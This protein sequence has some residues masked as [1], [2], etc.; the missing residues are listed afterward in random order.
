MS[1]SNHS[2]RRRAG[3]VT[4]YLRGARYWIYYRNGGQVRKPVGGNRSIAIALAAKVNAQLA[5]GAPTV[6]AFQPIDVTG[7]IAEWLD[8]HEHVRRS[9][10]ATVRRC[11]TA[12]AHLANYIATACGTHRAHRFDASTAEGFVR[13]LRTVEIS[14]DGHR[15]AKKRRMRDKGVVF[16][17]GT[18]RVRFNFAREQRHVPGYSPNPFAGLAIE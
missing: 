8:H 18:C 10:L 2:W 15:K 12:V 13:Y 14:P 6:L 3:R 7:L 9:S 4:V 17:L 1:R 5:E 16:A 11:R